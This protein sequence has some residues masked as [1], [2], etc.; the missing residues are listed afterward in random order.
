MSFYRWVPESVAAPPD[1]E[2]LAHRAVEQL[3]LRAIG[4]GVFPPTAEE[5]PDSEPI[6]GWQLWMWAKDPSPSTVGPISTSVSEAG[7]TVA[8]TAT[9]SGVDWDM[10][11]GDVVHC[12][13]GTKR[14]VGPAGVPNRKSPTCGYMYEQQGIYTVTATSR[15]SV[16]WS[17]IGQ[18]GVIELDLSASG[19]M[20]V[21]EVQVVNVYDP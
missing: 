15:W 4:L 19:T 7:F 21:G 11:N 2:V 3:D 18:A 6:V 20:E 10:G 9:L 17:G 13:V 5:S 1:P 16:A 14:V 8:A 12:G